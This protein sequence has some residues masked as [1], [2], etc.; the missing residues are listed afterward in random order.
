MY[1][2]PGD[3]L[4]MPVIGYVMFFPCFSHPEPVISQSTRPNEMLGAG[5]GRVEEEQKELEAQL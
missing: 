2:A 1:R 5:D 4:V 3:R